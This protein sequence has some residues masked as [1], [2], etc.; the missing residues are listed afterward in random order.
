MGTDQGFVPTF[1]A[2]TIFSAGGCP[3]CRN[4]TDAAVGVRAIE[5]ATWRR[6]ADRWIGSVNGV[7]VVSV[8]LDLEG[9]PRAAAAWARKTGRM[10][11]D[12]PVVSCPNCHELFARRRPVAATAS[13]TRDPLE[14]VRADCM[15]VLK[16]E[17][18]RRYE[19]RL[20][21]ESR[22]FNHRHSSAQ[23][24]ET[25][26]LTLSTSVAITVGGENELRYRGG[27]QVGKA[28]MTQLTATVEN[29]T[30]KSY[31][32]TR[33]TTLAVDQS[34]TVHVAAGH[35]VEVAL[36]WK[37]IWAECLTTLGVMNDDVEIPLVE[38]PSAVT[39][40]LGYDLAVRDIR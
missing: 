5:K 3:S 26:G 36:H 29:V 16:H 33:T 7:D 37:R 24:T 21:S 4:W 19:E 1:A 35:E 25:I 14:P 10:V 12:V 17:E 22:R 11:Y 13:W 9:P 15:V 8:S 30:R 38:V 23:S 18:I 28:G 31:A 2:V 6:G 27:L 32:I 39:V 40:N 20:G 34:T